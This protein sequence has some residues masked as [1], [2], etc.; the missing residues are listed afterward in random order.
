MDVVEFR[1]SHYAELAGIWERY[2]WTPPSEEVLPKRGYVMISG[3]KVVGA[4]F[5]YISCSGMA[6]LDWIVVDP[7]AHPMARGKC[8]HKTIQACLDYS[9][10][11]GKTVAYT[12]TANKSLLKALKKLGFQDMET[13]ATTMAMSLDG[14]KTDFLR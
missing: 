12:V 3:G 11:L 2:G 5:I 8:V 7:L 9:K 4:S 14:T 1:T 10:S 6:Y 13:H